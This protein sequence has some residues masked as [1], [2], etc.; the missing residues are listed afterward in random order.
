MSEPIA[1]QGSGCCPGHT[2]KTDGVL[3]L[4]RSDPC[5]PLP[6]FISPQLGTP[7]EKPPAGDRWLHEIKF[8]G[9]RTGARIETGNVCFARLGPLAAYDRDRVDNLSKGCSPTA[10]RGPLRRRLTRG[11]D[12]LG[13]LGRILQASAR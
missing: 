9:Y 4:M 8:D 6:G 13:G 7:V 1:L 2:P 10:T 5:A 12:V 11:V 3:D